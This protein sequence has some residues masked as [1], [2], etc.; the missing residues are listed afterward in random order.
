MFSNKLNRKVYISDQHVQTNANLGFPCY[1]TKAQAPC[2]CYVVRLGFAAQVFRNLV[3]GARMATSRPSSSLQGSQLGKPTWVDKVATLRPI[4]RQL[5]SEPLCETNLESQVGRFEADQQLAAKPNQQAKVLNPAKPNARV[6]ISMGWVVHLP[7]LFLLVLG[8][9]RAAM[10]V[11]QR[12][13]LTYHS[14]ELT[15]VGVWVRWVWCG[16]WAGG[17]VCWLVGLLACWVRVCCCRVGCL[18]GCGCVGPW[19]LGLVVS[20]CV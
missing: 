18:C 5:Q 19:G 17:W 14:R 6:G 9:W 7:K 11:Q 12:F 15:V 1:L 2:S 8:S 20:V 10:P 4:S 3:S 16:L 13:C